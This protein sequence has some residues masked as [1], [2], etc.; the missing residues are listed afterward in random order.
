LIINEKLDGVLQKQ[1]NSSQWVKI[2]VSVFGIFFLGI[3]YAG[4]KDHLKIEQMPN[5]Y[6]KK[7]YYDKYIENIDSK[8]K[9]VLQTKLDTKKDI[10]ELEEKL[11]NNDS[12]FNYLKITRGA[13][14]KNPIREPKK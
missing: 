9:E 14:K 5:D 6:V 13:T 12:L 7:E 10:I 1:Q 2:L 8:V 3:V 4:I 11:K